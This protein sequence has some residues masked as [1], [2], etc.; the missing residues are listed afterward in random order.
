MVVDQEDVP[1]I[2]EVIRASGYSSSQFHLWL[3]QGACER[4]ERE[5][6]VVCEQTIEAAIDVIKTYPHFSGVK[7][8]VYMVYH[9]LGFIPQHF[10]KELK[11]MVRRLV[12]Q[13]VSTQNLLPERTSYTHERAEAPGE[14]WAE[15]FTQIMVYNHRYY[16]ALVMDVK[17]QYYLGA[18]SS[19]RASK[20]FVALPLDQAV[21]ENQGKGPQKFLLSDNG[22]Q[23]ID[24]V[25]EDH[26]DMLDIIHKKIPACTP[27]YNGTVECGVK[28]F[29]NVFYPLF[30]R[31]EQEKDTDKKEKL[32]IRVAKTVEQCRTLLNNSIPRVSLNGIT[33]LD[34]HKGNACKKI[35]DNQEWSNEEKKR[36]RKEGILKTKSLW[37]SVKKRLFSKPLSKLQLMT[38]FCFFLKRPLRKVTK[39][40]PEVLGNFWSISS[41]FS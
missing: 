1:R 16:I 27:Q 35:R 25:H 21:A 12:F 40:I 8:Q 41:D 14:I 36:N 32:S 22:K 13:E 19:T 10:Y 37:N 5:K 31:L 29:K 34:V 15:D 3:K 4:K 18:C 9:R 30:A 7:G 17:S 26:L 38:I 39:L 33:P 28:E 11:R 20:Q 23:Y 6:K 2:D 24:K